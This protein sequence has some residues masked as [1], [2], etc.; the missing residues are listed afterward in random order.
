MKK[1]FLLILMIITLVSNTWAF[2][3][4]ERQGSATLNYIVDGET[5]AVVDN[6]LSSGLKLPTAPKKDGYDFN[7]WYLDEGTYNNPLSKDTLRD[8][9]DGDT[10]GVYA[11]YSTHVHAYDEMIKQPTCTE[12]GFTVCICDCGENVIKDEVE[13]IGHGFLDYV[14]NYNGTETATCFRE[15][16]SAID[17]R[18]ADE[19]VQA[20]SP[21]IKLNT[22]SAKVGYLD[23][24]RLEAT[25]VMGDYEFTFESLDDT[26]ATVSSEGEIFGVKGGKTSIRVISDKDVA[27][28]SV[29]VGLIYDFPTAIIYGLNEESDTISVNENAEFDLV[30]GVLY[31]GVVYS[32]V[33]AT[34]ALS[35]ETIGKIENDKFIA[36]ALSS[37][38][39]KTCKLTVSATWHGFSCEQAP[40]LLKEVN[41]KVSKPSVANVSYI[42]INGIPITNKPFEV[43]VGETVAF[44]ISGVIDGAS[45]SGLTLLRV[46]YSRTGYVVANGT[47]IQA[48]KAGEVNVILRRKTWT[49]KH[50]EGVSMFTIPVVIVE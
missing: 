3:A 26:I 42:T 22:Y 17:T 34:F 28:C 27:Y 11:L 23:T 1:K 9:K 6:S 48:K 31:G 4:C 21:M 10:L 25:H 7:G 2:S 12:K 15:N 38:T 14:P 35:D 5:V 46:S 50:V 29:E 33:E 32:D 37:S 20:S 8:L 45:T 30:V 24:F 44:A 47:T 36:S 40:M 16:C 18:K 19:D 13:P 43:K 41:I 39:A 49:G